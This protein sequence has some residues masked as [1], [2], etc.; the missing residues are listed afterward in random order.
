MRGLFNRVGRGVVAAAVVVML[1]APV[2]E[3]KP[4]DPGW[5]PSKLLKAVKRFVVTTFG[6]GIIVP[7]P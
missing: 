2:V 7:R 1:A 5:T 3:A 6:D 4:S